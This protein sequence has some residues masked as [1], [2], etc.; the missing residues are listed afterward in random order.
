M[1]PAKPVQ[2]V[3][4]TAVHV[5]IWFRVVIQFSASNL[6]PSGSAKQT[7]YH[8]YRFPQ[9]LVSIQ[10]H[11]FIY[12]NILSCIITIVVIVRQLSSF[13]SATRTREIWMKVHKLEMWLNYWVPDPKHAPLFQCK[14]HMYRKTVLISGNGDVV[15]W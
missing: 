14:R 12:M 3:P 7:V 11:L 1:G 10:Y 9:Y 5:N 6:L 13:S 2:W 15:P 4:Y 8:T